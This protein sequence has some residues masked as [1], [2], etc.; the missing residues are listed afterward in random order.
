M[1]ASRGRSF[2]YFSIFVVIFG[3]GV[4]PAKQAAT[5]QATQ[6]KDQFRRALKADSQLEPDAHTGR[7][8]IVRSGDGLACREMTARELEQFQMDKGRT[9]LQV[10]SDPRP[11]SL[12]AQQGLKI[13][14]RGTQQLEAFQTAKQAFLRA[15]AKWE[16]IIQSPITVVLDVDFGP[17]IFGTPFPSPNIIGGTSPQLLTGRNLYGNVRISLL[18]RSAN[19]RQVRIFSI[20]PGIL[21]T[22]LGPTAN[23]AGTS[24]QLRALGQIPPVADPNTETAT[25]GPPP[26]IGF[27]SD[28]N[29]DFDPTDGIDT[30]KT[31][32]EAVAIHELGHALGF[33]SGVGNRESAPSTALLAPTVWDIFRF[34]PGGL[35]NNAFATGNRVQIAGGTQV[36]FVGDAEL[37]LSTATSNG[38]GGDGQQ[39]SHWKDNGQIGTYTG[40]MDPTAASGERLTITANDLTALS[41]MGYKVNPSSSV[42]EVLS[43]DDGSRE[44]ALALTNAIVVNRYTPTRYPA[45]LQSVR[46]QIPPTT[47]GSSPVGQSLRIVAF[48]DANRTGQP[49]ANPTLIVDRTVTIPNIPGSRFIEVPLTTPLTNVTDVAAQQNPPPIT[50]GDLYVGVQSTNTSVLI[51]GDRSGKQQNRSFVSTNN[52]GSFTPLQNATNQPL[53]FISRVVLAESFGATPSPALASISP[54]AAT[55]GSSAFTLYVQGSNFQL[56]S[57]VRWNNSDRPTTFVSGT[58]LQAQIA[59]ADLANA[60]TANVTVFTANAAESVAAVFKIEAN[61]PAPLATRLS[62]ASQAAGVT[63]PLELTVFGSDFTPQSEIRYNGN[64]RTTTFV[65]STQLTTTLQPGDFASAADN[66]ITVFTPGPGGGTSAELSFPVVSCTL[67]LSTTSQLFSSSNLTGPTNPFTGGIVIN[68]NNDACPWALTVGAPWVTLVSPQNGQ[69]K[70]KFVLSYLIEQNASASGRSTTLGVS[71]QTL[72][73]RQLGRI[74]SVSAAR[75]TAPLA[76]NSIAASFG[77]GLARSTQVATTQ[78]LP[79]TLNGVNV[80][81][82]DSRNASRLAQLFFVADSQINLLIPTGTAA[83]N[84]IVRTAID[85]SFVADGIVE[86]TSV[87][88]ALFTTNSSG[89]GLAAAVLLRVKAD[90]SQIYEPISRFDSTTNSV[91]PVPIDFGAATDRLFLLLYGSGIGGRSSLNAVTVQVGGENAPVSYAGAA[92]GFAGLDQINAELPRTLIGKGTVTVNLTVDNRTANP[93]TVTFK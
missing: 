50:A 67:S 68:A 60:G 69:G 19:D 51:A 80:L 58:L 38:T 52:F 24:A 75:F 29:F 85:G 37:P 25:L 26:S 66:K 42:T 48:L 22:D 53:N 34:R 17:T 7:Y 46:V 28:F 32:F 13:I 11:E 44:E 76:P 16:S 47:D 71:N 18:D 15:A 10:I 78:P 9:N 82:I 8:L 36:H 39:S 65:N 12:Q 81:V 92:E 35:D 49:P 3:F 57:V 88:P 6:S 83:G 45:T 93:V 77:V 30:E 55:P 23:I 91:V 43:V 74:G 70:G 14:L 54:S 61:R 33:I 56:N 86:I 4:L 40:V 64:A 5:L 79:T 20:L 63:T 62:P 89:N 2:V 27:N 84:A 21:P 90:G 87:A 72:N 1:N 41:F 59:P 73:I 31:D